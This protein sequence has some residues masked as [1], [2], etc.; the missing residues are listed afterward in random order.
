[1]EQLIGQV[2]N[3][4]YCI[5]SLLGRQKGR[6]TFLADD[7]PTGSTVV[8]KILLLSPEFTWDDLKLFERE[9]ATL[10]SLNHTSIP[11]YIDYFEL[12]TELG[13]G[14]ALVQNYIEAKSLQNWIESGRSFSEEEI[15]N[16]AIQLLNILNYLHQRQPSVIHRDIKPSNILLG[17]R[18][19]HNVGQV[20]LVDFGSV[21]TVLHG[22]TKTIVGTYGYMPPEQFGDRCLPA[23]DLYAVGATLIYLATGYPPNELPQKE[24]R[25]LFADKVNLSV[26][27]VNW[28]QWLTEPSLDLRLN[29]AEEA[30]EALQE[31]RLQK[32]HSTKLVQPTGSKIRLRQTLEMFDILIPPHGFHLALI[33]LIGFAVAWNSF[34]LV[35]Y[36]GALATWSSGGW[37]AAL[38]AICHLG[39]GIGLI[40]AI[41]FALFGT[42]RLR[43]TSSEI[44]LVYKILGLVCSPWLK[45]SRQ[46]II[47]L[48]QTA[49]SYKK[50]SDGDQVQ[51]PSKI[52]IWAGTKK[53]SLGDNL[54]DPELDWL[55]YNLSNWLKLPISKQ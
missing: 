8:V 27:M 20:Y 7:L 48:E 3:H 54:S 44:I 35:W 46:D 50:D 38:F 31:D 34:L 25:L 18:S 11:Q 10:K 43:I 52:N 14:F 36:A 4:Q 55:A 47:K 39:V 1:M 5:K 32:S 15:K 51:I 2:L 40:W 22:G 26:N 21:Q 12:E 33:P 28:L 19:G 42:I 53:F 30:L 24:M 41:L 13:K 45:A 37:F 16:I 6:R 17:D 23:S 9:A 49:L 29:S